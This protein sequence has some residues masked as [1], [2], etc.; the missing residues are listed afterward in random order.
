MTARS[1]MTQ[2]ALVERATSG[3]ADDYNHATTS[4]WNTHIPAMPCWLY[5]AEEAEVVG[6]ERTVVVGALKL[7]APRSADLT[8]RDRING[9]KDRLGE[10][11]EPG[12]L[13]IESILRKRS[14]L[15]IV[16]SKVAA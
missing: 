6:A 2:R 16:V 4:G 9:V 14:H 11:V 12:I 10:I 15:E 3:A 8:E 5:E 7:L 13:G 1:R